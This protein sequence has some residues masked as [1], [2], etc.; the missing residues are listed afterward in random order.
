MK[1]EATREEIIKLHNKITEI[2]ESNKEQDSRFL[3][4]LN[5]TRSY[6]DDEVNSLRETNKPSES[7]IEYNQKKQQLMFD[8]CEKNE[9]GTAN[10]VN[11][12]QFRLVGENSDKVQKNLIELDSEYQVA[13]EEFKKK[14]DQ[15]KETL[16]EKIEVEVLKCS[17]KFFP[18]IIDPDTLN[19]LSLLIK[20]TDSELEELLSL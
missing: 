5:R 18:K 8:L 15:L 2:V 7:Y 19:I 17:F 12:N 13:I 3:F 20:E 1:V 11:G 9:D 16:K 14:D 4:S 6:L 10:L